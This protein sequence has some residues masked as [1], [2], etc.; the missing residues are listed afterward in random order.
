MGDTELWEIINIT[1]DAHP[2]HTHLASFQIVNR[3]A[4]QAS[5]WTT[6]YTNALAAPWTCI[7]DGQGPPNPYLTPNADG[8][9]G[10]N[11]AIGPYLQGTS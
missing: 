1:A 10:G 9:I 11:P 3:Q 2:M 6:V 8:A 4:F 7:L 5:K